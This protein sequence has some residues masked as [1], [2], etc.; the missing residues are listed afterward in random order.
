VRGPLSEGRPEEVG[1]SPMPTASEAQTT[2]YHKPWLIPAKRKNRNVPDEILI[3]D[4]V[5]HDFGF[6]KR[7]RR[8]GENQRLPRC[9]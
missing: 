7:K 5:V 3:P 4:Y 9:L 1:A 2:T 8:A 6:P